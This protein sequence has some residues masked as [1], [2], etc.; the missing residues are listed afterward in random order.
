MGGIRYLEGVENLIREIKTTQGEN[1]KKASEIVAHSIMNGGIVYSF[2]SGHSFIVAVEIT[3]RAGGLV[4]VKV[5]EEPSKGLYERIE[6]VGYKLMER[7]HFSP[8]DCFIIISNSGRN[9]LI[10]EVADFIKQKGNRIIAVTSLNVSKKLKSR[11]SLGKNLYQFADVV[12]DNCVKEGDATI[13][14]KGLPVKVGPV[15]TIAAIALLQATI[16]EAVKVMLALG[17]TPPIY[18]S[19]NIDGG[20]EYNRKLIEEYGRKYQGIENI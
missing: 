20:P 15:S 18:M 2:G 16:V 10:I 17:Y 13:E 5:I 1:I 8:N 19:D 12:L 9:P 7:Y 4:P 14:F 11:H 3:E 6:G